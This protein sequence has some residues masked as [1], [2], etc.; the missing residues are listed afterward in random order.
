LDA[1]PVMGKTITTDPQTGN[2]VVAILAVVSTLGKL[3]QSHQVRSH[4]YREKGLRIYG[5][6]SPSHTTRLEP[7]VVLRMVFFSNNRRCCA[8]SLP[9]VQLWLMQ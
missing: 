9:Q 2:V 8:H 7:T 4:S 6:F 3:L 5:I 1:G